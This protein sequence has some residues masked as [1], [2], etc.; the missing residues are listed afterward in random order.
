MYEMLDTLAVLSLK[1]AK[2]SYGR[3]Q[4]R[5]LG[6]GHMQRHR[7]VRL[8]I[9]HKNSSKRHGND[10]KGNITKGIPN[11]KRILVRLKKIAIAIAAKII[12]ELISDI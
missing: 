1:Y 8:R 9:A 5:L 2:I 7:Y 6:G 10:R 11:S 12:P 4:R 3:R